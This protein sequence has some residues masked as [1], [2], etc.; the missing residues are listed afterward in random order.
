MLPMQ[1]WSCTLFNVACKGGNIH[2]LENLRYGC[3]VDVYICY[4]SCF[5]A[6]GLIFFITIECIQQS[7]RPIMQF[8]KPD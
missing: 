2:S 6:G 7:H 4:I 1:M 8:V 5:S 3:Y